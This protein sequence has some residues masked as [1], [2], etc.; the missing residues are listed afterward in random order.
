MSRSDSPEWALLKQVRRCL[1][2]ESILT[3]IGPDQ[4]AGEPS[5]VTGV[6][7]QQ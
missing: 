6:L 1:F 2:L 7:F 5:A 4:Y 3:A